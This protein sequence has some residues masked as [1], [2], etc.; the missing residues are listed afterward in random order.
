MLGKDLILSLNCLC[1]AEFSDG[2]CNFILYF[3]ILEASDGPTLKRSTP[4]RMAYNRSMYFEDRSI[5]L[6]WELVV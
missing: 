2:V 5:K 6:K 4:N 1:E 3:V